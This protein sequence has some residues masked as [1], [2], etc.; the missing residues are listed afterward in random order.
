MAQ[1]VNYN[2]KD[3][4]IN[5]LLLMMKNELNYT[6][7]YVSCPSNVESGMF[8]AGQLNQLFKLHKLPVSATQKI[9]NILKNAQQQLVQALSKELEVLKEF[10]KVLGNVPGSGAVTSLEKLC[11]LINMQHKLMKSHHWKFPSDISQYVENKI[12][13]LEKLA[14]TVFMKLPNGKPNTNTSNKT[15]SKEQQSHNRIPPSSSKSLIAPASRQKDD[16]E[17]VCEKTIVGTSPTRQFQRHVPPSVVHPSKQ[18]Q[19]QTAVPGT[20]PTVNKSRNTSEDCA[21]IVCEKSVITPSS[22]VRQLPTHQQPVN[23]G[24]ASH[25]GPTGLRRPLIRNSNSGDFTNTSRPV[26]V[27]R[28]NS[29]NSTSTQP[30]SAVN[31]PQFQNKNPGKILPQRRD[32]QISMKQSIKSSSHEEIILDNDVPPKR[33]EQD[34]EVIEDNPNLP[35]VRP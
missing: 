18:Y 1:K 4:N 19:R 29:T 15:F 24:Q 27:R 10:E 20:R 34:C 8:T 21:E 30:T 5:Q 14:A 23:K 31:K 16:A 22:R 6:K 35:V 7:Q 13:C 33:K 2:F 28:K 9:D 12:T 11:S 3:A 32:V 17:I 26:P 25:E